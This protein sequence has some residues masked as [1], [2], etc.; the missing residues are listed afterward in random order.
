[1]LSYQHIKKYA[2]EAGFSAVGVA[3]ARVLTEQGP[4]FAAALAASG[5]A[6]LGYLVRAPERRLDPGRLV[7]GARTVVVCAL[8]YDPRPVETPEGLVSAHR[9]AGDY[10]PRIV[11]M[12]SGVL[13]RLRSEEPGVAGRVFCDT[14]PILEKAWA[15][16]AGLGWIGRHSL[17]VHPALGSFLLLG[18]LVLDGE[19]D[20]YDR[21]VRGV[22]CGECRRCVEECPAGAL[23]EGCGKAP[24]EAF[25]EVA[26]VDTGRCVSA[27]TIE[28]SRGGA[29]SPGDLHGWIWGCDVC[30]NVCPRN[31]KNMAG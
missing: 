10:H 7:E 3:R 6:A 8:A 18:G 11:A 27:L 24:G 5:E 25:G 19:C 20:R 9:G 30:Q 14:A 31:K 26:A 17:L 13:E 23:I 1:M 28:S 22:G 4:R 21:P 16:E 12:L 2:A 15:V 29:V